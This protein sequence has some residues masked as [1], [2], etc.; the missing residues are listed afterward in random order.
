MRVDAKMIMRNA[1]FCDCVLGDNAARLAADEVADQWE[2][3]VPQRRIELRFVDSGD[4][5]KEALVHLHASHPVTDWRMRPL[6]LRDRGHWPW[7]EPLAGDL[8][9][10]EGDPGPIALRA[11]Q[12]AAHPHCAG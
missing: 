6:A 10:Q 3:I 12:A 2:H 4:E 9:E 8:V 1:C 7:L 11:R 5:L